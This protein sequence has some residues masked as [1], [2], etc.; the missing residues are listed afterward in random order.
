MEVTLR[1]PIDPNTGW[2]VD[3]DELHPVWLPLFSQLDHHLLNEVPGLE[4]P[5]SE[6]LAGWIMDRLVIQGAVVCKVKVHETCTS[7]ATLYLAG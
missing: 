5:T 1:G 3:F 2:I 6:V 4:N 7:S